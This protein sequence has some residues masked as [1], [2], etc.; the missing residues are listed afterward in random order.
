M[1]IETKAMERVMQFLNTAKA[2]ESLKTLTEEIKDLEGSKEDKAEQLA[3]YLKI[4]IKT[5]NPKQE[6]VKSLIY[7]LCSISYGV[8]DF[9]KIASNYIDKYDL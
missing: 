3:N 1:D 7:D 9:K 2:R 8:I 4:Y 6:E 5:R